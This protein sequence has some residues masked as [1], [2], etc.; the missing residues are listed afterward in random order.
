MI[1]RLNITLGL[2]LLGLAGCQSEPTPSPGMSG[3]SIRVIAEP[4]SG[5]RDAG[6]GVKVY[7]APVVKEQGQFEKVDYSALDDI[8]VW[9]EPVSASAPVNGAAVT[10]SVDAHKPAEKLS[11]VAGVGQRLILHNSGPGA[12]NLYSVSDGNDFDLG[13]VAAGGHGH[14]TVRSSGL[15]EVL[16]ASDRDPVAEIYAAPS[17]WVALTHSGAT[18]EFTNLPPGRYKICSWHP[19]LPGTEES[20][21][22]AANQILK[23]TIKVGVNALPKVGPR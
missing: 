14:Y 6:G 19:R 11:A 12:L 16:A 8:V 7:D 2:L 5:V 10:V 18:V 3:M 15:I 1:S 17:R 20:V 21:T 13:K 4:K 23:T 9:A 22:L